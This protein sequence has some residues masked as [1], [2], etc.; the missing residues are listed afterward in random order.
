[1]ATHLGTRQ[2]AALRTIEQVGRSALDDVRS[3]LTE[4]RGSRTADSPSVQ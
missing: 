3:V 1:M 4:Y 2:D